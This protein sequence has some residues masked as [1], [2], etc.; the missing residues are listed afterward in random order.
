ML[1]SARTRLF[2]VTWRAMLEPVLFHRH[3]RRETNEGDGTVPNGADDATPGADAI[4]AWLGITIPEECRA[5]VAANLA[6]LTR[7][8]AVVQAAEAAAP[9][10]PAELLRP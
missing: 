9:A 2:V 7:H 4:A 1:L 5:G 3:T 10:D 8:M 6:V